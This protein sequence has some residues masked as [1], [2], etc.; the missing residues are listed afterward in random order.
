[1]QKLW[2]T[3][4][5][6]GRCTKIQRNAKSWSTLA[7]RMLCA[8]RQIAPD[9]FSRFH[10]LVGQF[11][12]TSARH[13]SEGIAYTDSGKQPNIVFTGIPGVGKTS[14]CELLIRL[15]A[16]NIFASVTKA[17]TTPTKVGLWTKT[18]WDVSKNCSTKT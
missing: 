12:T 16:S 10:V 9:F 1:M 2:Q 6:A 5:I 14:H 18:R 7:E 15:Q 11:F 4:S 8:T 3:S 17:G 13:S